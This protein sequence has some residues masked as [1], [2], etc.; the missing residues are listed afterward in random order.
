MSAAPFGRPHG[1]RTMT[2][3]ELDRL[4]QAKREAQAEWERLA[5]ES[6]TLRGLLRQANRRTVEAAGL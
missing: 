2:P 6:A 1:G 3:V 4:N 5:A